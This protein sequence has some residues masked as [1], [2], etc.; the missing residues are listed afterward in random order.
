MSGSATFGVLDV[1]NE[2]LVALRVLT[3]W[4]DGKMPTSEDIQLLHFFK[5]ECGDLPP[6]ELACIVMADERKP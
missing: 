6:D 1:P 2:K 4:M 3:C 5:P